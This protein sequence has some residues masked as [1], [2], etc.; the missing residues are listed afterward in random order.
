MKYKVRI[1]MD[2]TVEVEA[3]S[4]EGAEELAWQEITDAGAWGLTIE[5][6]E[7]LEVH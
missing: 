2:E 6:V 4:E 3:E 7:E 5:E 1:T